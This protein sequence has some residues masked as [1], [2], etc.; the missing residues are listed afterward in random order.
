MSDLE[1]I[2]PVEMA[3]FDLFE[4]KLKVKMFLKEPSSTG[5]LVKFEQERKIRLLSVLADDGSIHFTNP[6]NPSSAIR[7]TVYNFKCV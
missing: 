7:F 5:V 6:D 3:I 4:W 2:E 1:K